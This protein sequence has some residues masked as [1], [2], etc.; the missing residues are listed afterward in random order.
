MLCTALSSASPR[1]PSPHTV[2][3]EEGEAEFASSQEAQM[4]FLEQ[5]MKAEVPTREAKMEQIMKTIS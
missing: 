3:L 4:P 5:T 1:T 2:D